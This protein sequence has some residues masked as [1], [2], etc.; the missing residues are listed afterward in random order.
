MSEDSDKKRKNDHQDASEAQGPL[1]NTAN[2]PPSPTAHRRKQSKKEKRYNF[3]PLN[4]LDNEQLAPTN[5]LK[6]ISVSQV[7]NT[8][9]SENRVK[10]EIPKGL[11]PPKHVLRKVPSYKSK[12]K[13]KITD[14]KAQRDSDELSE[15]VV[16]QNSPLRAD[17]EKKTFS[18]PESKDGSLPNLGNA[19]STPV[20]ANRLR[21]ILTFTHMP[22]SDTGKDNAAPVE[23]ED[24][25]IGPQFQESS[26][27]KGVQRNIMDILNEMKN[28]TDLNTGGNKLDD[29]PSSPESF[30]GQHQPSQEN[31]DTTEFGGALVRNELNVPADGT[32]TGK[33]NRLTMTEVKAEPSHLLQSTEANP[34]DKIPNISEPKS[35][36]QVSHHSES[37]IVELTIDVKTESTNIAKIDEMNPIKSSSIIEGDVKSNSSIHN[38]YDFDDDD[39]D[40]L[41]E[42][43]SQ[44]N[45]SQ[46][47]RAAQEKKNND[48]NNPP[49]D[50]QTDSLSDDDMLDDSL[51]DLLAKGKNQKVMQPAE[52]V[53]NDTP[54]SIEV[55]TNDANTTETYTRLAQCA[56]ERD[57]VTRLVIKSIRSLTLP[58]NTQQKIMSCIDHNGSI[59]TIILRSPWVFLELTEGDV[60]HTIEGKNS[61]N[62]RLFTM[63][64]DPI[65]KTSNDNLLVVHPDML[66]S[67]TAIG[68]SYKCLRN[69]VIDNLFQDIRG[70][71]S[72]A[73]TI[74][75]IVHEL[76]QDALKQK[77]TT[78]SLSMEYIE[79]KLDSLLADFSF[80]I[81][82]C[83]ETVE[84]VKE[85][86]TQIHL[87]NIF[88]FV[89]KFVSQDNFGKYISDSDTRKEKPTSITDIIDIEENIWSHIY[90]LKGFLDVTIN[91]RVE[92]SQNI[93][94]LEVK[95]G[96]F[97][98]DAHRVQGLIYTLLLSDKYDMPV[99]FFYLLYTTEEQMTSYPRLTNIM[100]DVIMIR[101]MLAI[102][103]KHRLSEIKDYNYVDFHLPPMINTDSC[104][105][106]FKKNECMVLHKLMEDGSAEDVS[107]PSNDF[108]LLTSHLTGNI[109]KYKEFFLKYNDLI[110]KEESSVCHMNQ[111]LFL[112]DSKTRE[113]VSGHCVGNLSIAQI[114]KDHTREGAFIY[115]FHRKAGSSQVYQ[116]MIHSQISVN[117]LVIISDEDGHFSLSNGFVTEISSNVIKVSTTRRLLNNRRIAGQDH[118]TIVESVI[119]PTLRDSD[120]LSTQN[121]VSY[122]IDKNDIQ[123]S[124]SGSRFNLLNIFLPP[125]EPGSFTMDEKTKE[126]H[127]FKPSEGG[128]EKMRRFMVDEVAPRFIP[129]DKPP[130][131]DDGL[132]KNSTLNIDQRNAIEKCIR[133]QDYALI[134]GMPGTGKTTVITELVKLL[135]MSGKKILLTSYTHSAVD[136]ILLKLLDTDISTIRLGSPKKI[137]PGVQKYIPKYD[138]V[139]TY[140]Q[141]LRIINDV[142]LVATTCLG[143]KDLL[144]SLK[145]RDFDYVI[146][147]EASQVSMPVA[148]GPLRFGT[149]FIMVGDHNQL[150]PLVKNDCARVGGLEDSLFKMLSEMHPTSIAEL[151]LQYRMC[152]DIVKLSNFLIYDNKLKCGT[153]E[154]YNRSLQIPNIDAVSDHK[155]ASQGS[156]WLHDILDPSRKVV[157]ADYDSNSNIVEQSDGNNISNDGECDLVCQ[158]VDG[159][160]A[161]GIK[162]E[163]IGVMTLYRAQLRKLQKRLSGKRYTGLEVLTADQ[164]QGRDKDC[165]LISMVRSNSELKGG[166]LLREIRRVNVAMTRA[167]SKLVIFGSKKTIGSIGEIREFMNMLHDNGW[168]YQLPANCCNAYMF[169]HEN[170]SQRIMSQSGSKTK[171]AKNIQSNSRLLND[172]PIV[173]Q[174]LES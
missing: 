158:T 114:K 72:I 19:P 54:K 43:I 145:E 102:S 104:N 129:L 117:D 157:F 80:A 159:L 113:S 173:K 160:M 82:V 65:S 51:L 50:I 95:T 88:H 22:E 131:V 110:N 28:N 171:G 136:N 64:K 121:A 4:R 139:T 71:P 35:V 103:L 125:I 17:A 13:T 108:E 52:P 152:G 41:L 141:F 92:Q 130:L 172:K 167:K 142:S 165:I 97:K 162:C 44:K 79:A 116:S 53:N 36:D 123:Q 112:M 75:N 21:S 126:I 24:N 149:K 120:V 25:I 127:T 85:K 115:E 77:C 93:V 166:S 86:I 99:D 164:F 94:P 151:T 61:S 67:A 30:V 118:H 57:G 163:Q 140:N 143:L 91:A 32:A 6:A 31:I 7:R 27:P 98:S 168:I 26:S 3:Q 83:N 169:P 107:I 156:D 49:R 105:K 15:H 146:I 154:V 74:G 119:N 10:T 89:N 5:V 56:N 8:A 11:N 111:E 69:G 90:G 150:P 84:D 134:L 138:S 37:N 155:V 42:M 128:D 18:S 48:I 46:K 59:T 38:D 1:D 153:D 96:K 109:Q 132:L 23:L 124:L 133:A 45:T 137:H 33:D 29:L 174:T 2:K 20:V 70:E 73:M 135:V 39:E 60:I 147:D 87:S 12:T 68:N 101:N 170:D 58:N 63:E 161:I 81:I 14:T 16:W 148:L 55:N 76:L 9:F 66:L 62:K 78:D 100:R 47:N 34:I 122:R 40:E 106:C 144:F